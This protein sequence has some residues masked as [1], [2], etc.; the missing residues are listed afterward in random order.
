[1]EEK[2]EFEK[3][4]LI[5]DLNQIKSE[6]IYFLLH[7]D[8]ESVF[9][10]SKNISKYPII[11]FFGILK[12]V[13]SLENDGW[14]K[15]RVISYIKHYSVIDKKTFQKKLDSTISKSREKLQVQK[16]SCY[17]I[18]DIVKKSERR[19]K[20]QKKEN[21]KELKEFQEQDFKISDQSPEFIKDFLKKISK[22]PTLT[23]FKS[24][25]N[26]V[27]ML[28]TKN[29]T[30]SLNS[31]EIE[32]NSQKKT[33][34]GGIIFCSIESKE[35]SVEL[36]E[37]IHTYN[38][39]GLKFMYKLETK[40]YMDNKI[41]GLSDFSFEEQILNIEK[42]GIQTNF[43]LKTPNFST[44]GVVETAL[45]SENPLI[46]GSIWAENDDFL[47]IIKKNISM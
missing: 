27:V 41:R 9:E 12:E 15:S 8:M 20:K 29:I 16:E 23:P 26:I 3:K 33:L 38:S 25:I 47:T 22:I 5:F 7:R 42:M 21:K 13:K 18:L 14:I 19:K 35:F 17:T 6:I 10:I 30:F 40:G 2:S 46:I 4:I 24:E 36:F 31:L 11:N 32:M 45:Y 39:N 28:K 44:N 34:Y 37:E 43:S 1:M